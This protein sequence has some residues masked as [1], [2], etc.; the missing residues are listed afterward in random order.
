MKKVLALT[1][2][3]A[4]LMSGLVGSTATAAPAPP[5]PAVTPSNLVEGTLAGPSKAKQ[6]GVRLKTQQDS[7]VRQFTLTYDP[8]ADSGWHYHPGIVVATVL[9]GSVV[10]QVGCTRTIYTAKQSFTEVA[11][12]R[13]RNRGTV[14]AV[15]AITQIFPAG[16]LPRE[17]VASP[18][19]RR[20]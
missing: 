20:S 11:P 17:N 8:G 10:Q 5:T 6:D 16:E 7:T 14:P 4:L 18:C 15:L 12:H 1:G 19:P 9:S 3:A 2:S 13:V